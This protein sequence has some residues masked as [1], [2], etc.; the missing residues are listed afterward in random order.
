MQ[1]VHHTTHQDPHCGCPAALA[2]D[3]KN[4]CC[5]LLRFALLLQTSSTLI[6]CTRT[7]TVQVCPC[8]HDAQRAP[9]ML[10]L[11]SCCHRCHCQIHCLQL[12]LAAQPKLPAAASTVPAWR[13]LPV[14]AAAAATAHHRPRERWPLPIPA[15]REHA[16]RATANLSAWASTLLH[17]ARMFITT[18]AVGL[19]YNNSRA[20]LAHACH[21]QEGRVGPC[22]H[23]R[24]AGAAYQAPS[25]VGGHHGG[26]S[27]PCGPQMD[28]H[29]QSLAGQILAASLASAHR[30][31]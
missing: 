4:T 12:Q 19:R 21:L 7:F 5:L 28:H 30:K 22:H 6:L 24:R 8:A 27:A 3:D 15:W 17:I 23:Q 31:E 11:V 16:C 1:R 13:L 14:P 25:P 18:I 9:A 26:Q 29:A 10:L 2:G 20:H